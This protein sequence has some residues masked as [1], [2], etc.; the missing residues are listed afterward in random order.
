[1]SP[2]TVYKQLTLLAS[3]VALALLSC[4]A[5]AGHSSID[6]VVA[7]GASL[8]DTGNGFIW[9]SEPANQSCGTRLNVPPYDALD[10]LLVPDGPY[11]KGGHH[12]S[13]GATWLEGLARDLALAGNARPALQNTGMEASNY[14]VFG[15]RAVANF[16]CRFN[17]PEQVG[18]YLEDF[19][20]TS[21][22]TLIAIEIGG[23]DVRD[24][25]VEVATSG[26]PD[27]AIP[28]IEGALGS[29]VININRLYGNGA[30]KFLVLNVPDLGKAPAVRALGPT[31]VFLGGSLSAFYN[32]GLAAVVQSLRALPGIDIRILDVYAKVNAVVA[33]PATYGFSNVTDAC[34]TPDEPPFK[35]AKPDTYLFWDGIHPTKAFHAIIAQ[36]AISVISAP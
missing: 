13:N 22:H 36:Q 12:F 17:L 24:A 8:T 35:C 32:A 3:S 23:N 20:Q 21:A 1:M 11:A 2:S 25:F 27:A 7:F 15:A 33:N 18:T 29:I 14:A 5:L 9:L 16:P 34:I 28:F 10:D 31:A 4:P 30:R 26:D 19:P 6:R